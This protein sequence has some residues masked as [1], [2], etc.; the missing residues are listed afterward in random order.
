MVHVVSVYDQFHA[1]L[2]AARLGSEGIV[3]ELRP[4]LGGPYPLPGEVAIYVSEE[5]L[6]SAR[7]VL[8]PSG[9]EV[10]ALGAEE[11]LDEEGL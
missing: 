11:E 5:D 6:A 9:A 1:R 7:A 3:T 10:E 4:P 8:E 2:L